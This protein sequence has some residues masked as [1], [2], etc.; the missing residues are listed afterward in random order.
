VQICNTLQKKDCY[1]EA[2]AK[3]TLPF[4]PQAATFVQQL[5]TLNL[6]AGEFLL[7]KLLFR[8][9]HG[10]LGGHMKFNVKALLAAAGVAAFAFSPA[11]ANELGAWETKPGA[12]IG[13]SAGAPPPG[14]YMVGQVFTYQA[15]FAGPGINNGMAFGTTGKVAAQ[16]AVNADV[17][18]FVPG[19]TFL[20]ATYDFIIVPIFVMNGAGA[21]IGGITSGMFNTYVV[22]IELSWTK[23]A[24]TNF[25]VKTGLGMYVPTGTVQ[26]VNGLGN[27]GRSAWT[28]QPE[29]IL[30]YLGNGWNLSTAMY[31]EINTADTRTNYTTGDIFHADFTATYTIGKWTFGPVGY[32]AGQ[33]TNDKCPVGI[34][35]AFYPT[36]ATGFQRYSLAAVGAILQ[37]DFGP[38]TINVW[39]TQEVYAHASGAINAAGLDTSTITRGS[40]IWT[41]ISFALWNPPAPAAPPMFH[42]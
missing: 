9:F 31:Y 24:G 27:E 15:N 23:I 21:P 19:W 8:V 4:Q 39:G 14:I 36:G 42:K 38:V 29:L 16:A 13:T 40:T 7:A 5:G 3:F 37:Y 35:T 6:R 34:C 41:N 17:F 11:N 18:L 10:R 26:G 12:F 25:A 1:G 22:P 28:F 30:S 32:F 2:Q 20:G 33:V